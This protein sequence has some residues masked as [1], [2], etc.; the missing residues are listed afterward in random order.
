[1]AMHPMALRYTQYFPSNYYPNSMN[2]YKY[3][4]SQSIIEDWTHSV[5]LQFIQ[6]SDDKV[7]EIWNTKRAKIQSPLYTLEDCQSVIEDYKKLD[8]FTAANAGYLK[9]Y[10][11]LQALFVQQDAFKHLYESSFSSNF[12]FKNYPELIN[13][14]NIRNKTIGHP[15]NSGGEYCTIIQKT[16]NK[17]SY[18]L[19]I[20]DKNDQMLQFPINTIKLIIDQE[21][22]LFPLMKTY[23]LELKKIK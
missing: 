5:R 16:L 8:D 3:I 12:D 23:L 19:L 6:L 13:I 15:S 7:F 17:F 10:G 9:I 11:L 20:H 14:R 1:M 2:S 4:L 22:F 18:M 21:A